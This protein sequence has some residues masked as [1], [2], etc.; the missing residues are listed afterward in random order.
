LLRKIRREKKEKKR[1]EKKRTGGEAVRGE[2]RINASF[3]IV[4]FLFS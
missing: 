3:S 1:E 2:I 4:S